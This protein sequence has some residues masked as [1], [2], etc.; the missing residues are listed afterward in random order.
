MGI[1]YKKSTLYLVL[2]NKLSTSMLKKTVIDGRGHL[3]GRLASIVAKQLLSGDRIVVVRCEEILISGGLLRQ[4]MKYERFINKS[5]NSNPRRCGPIHYRAP[6][7]IFQRVVRGM[8]PHKSVKGAAALSRLMCYEGVPAPFDKT[9]R[10]VMPDALKL[11]RKS[12]GRAEVKLG[13]VSSLVREPR[14]RSFKYSTY[15]E[16]WLEALKSHKRAGKQ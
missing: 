10:K 15:I 12:R 7:K 2:N 14:F 4:K 1:F 16:C 3:L 6:A 5:H 13:D 8:T 9:K 11:I